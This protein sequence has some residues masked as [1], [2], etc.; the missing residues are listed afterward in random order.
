MSLYVW[1]CMHACMHINI[2]YECRRLTHSFAHLLVH[3]KTTQRPMGA[4][5]FFSLFVY[6]MAPV[7]SLRVLITHVG[8]H[9]FTAEVSDVV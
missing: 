1:A 2:W 9:G 6:V 5:S 8:L 4:C 3:I 7:C